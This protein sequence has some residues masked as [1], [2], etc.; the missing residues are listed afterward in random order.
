MEERFRSPHV[1]PHKVLGF[2]TQAITDFSSFIHRIDLRNRCYYACDCPGLGL[3]AQVRNT[4][5]SLSPREVCLFI[6]SQEKN[7]GNR[8][9]GESQ[10]AA[11]ARYLSDRLY[12]SS[13]H[14]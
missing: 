2:A 9:N 10:S 6:K 8:Q 3:L 5:P 14:T 12:E 7:L 11:D 13:A 4:F 1:D